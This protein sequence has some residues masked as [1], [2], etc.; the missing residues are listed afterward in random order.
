MDI[1]FHLSR[2]QKQGHGHTQGR[3]F[4]S[5]DR[6]RVLE[7]CSL[8]PRPKF[9]QGPLPLRKFK[10][11]KKEKRGPGYKVENDDD[12]G[13]FVLRNNLKIHFRKTRN[14]KIIS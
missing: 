4:G 6:Q 12:D 8:R 13:Y 1:L 7:R 5:N 14:F 3:P 10:S 2:H 11:F 9:H